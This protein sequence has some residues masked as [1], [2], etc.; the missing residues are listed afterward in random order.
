M[1]AKKT[2]D[3]VKYAYIRFISREMY[4]LKISSGRI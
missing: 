1:Q 4:K 3:V 2:M